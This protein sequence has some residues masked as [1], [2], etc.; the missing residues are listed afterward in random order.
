MIKIKI[1]LYRDRRSVGQFVLVSGPISPMN[2][3]IQPKVTSVQGGIFNVTIGKAAWEACSAT[4]NLGTNSAFAQGPKNATEKLNR[5][6]RS[7]ELT[8][9]QQSGIKSASPN[10]SPYLPCFFLFFFPHKLLLTIIF[11]C[12][13][14]G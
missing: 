12:V 2:S 9:S 10:I 3:A 6:D 4:W 8:S 13:Q 14:F 5:I 1:K 11:I 7:Q